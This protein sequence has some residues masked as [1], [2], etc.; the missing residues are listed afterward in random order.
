[1]TRFRAI[2]N[3]IWVARAAN[4]GISAFI[5]PSGR[6]QGK[7]A[8]FEEAVTLA[9]VGLGAENSLYTRF[10]DV[11]PGLFLVISILWLVRSRRD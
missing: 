1:M 9:R 10:G 2:E 3:R 5:T 4:T 6:V 11:F 8:V 7:T